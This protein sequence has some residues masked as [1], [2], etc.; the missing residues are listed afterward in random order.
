M[1]QL[2]R[3]ISRYKILH[4]LFWAYAAFSDYHIKSTY[5]KFPEHNFLPEVLTFIGFQILCVY[6]VVAHLLPRLFYR[7][8]IILFFVFMLL[9][10]GV[11]AAIYTVFTWFFV[12]FSS[13]HGS[14]RLGIVHFIVFVF[15]TTTVV[16]V[17]TFIMLIA[18]YFQKERLNKELEKERLEAEL[19]FLKAQMNPHFLFNAINSIYVLMDEDKK[20][21]KDTLMR[22]SSMLR[23]QLYGCAH[24][25]TSIA[26]E[27]EFLNNYIAL[28]KIRNSE[29]LH[30]TFDF[31][32][33]ESQS[34]IA[35]LLL[36]PFVENA[37]KHVSHFVDKPNFVTISA[38]ENEGRFLFTVENSFEKGRVNAEPGGIGLQNV[39]RRLQLLYAD[40][41]HL[42]I[43][44]DEDR[45]AV[46]LNIRIA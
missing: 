45:Y 11:I 13:A 14:G 28:E 37:F 36:I 22:F 5:S 15:D 24:P 12:D 19:D 29:N 26:Q 6:V 8:K 21:S 39:K 3:F 35:P 31:S 23:Y 18:H 42:L 10:I 46:T 2:L 41:H 16:I 1:K 9:T 43:A 44:E 32:C 30:V 34:N 7:Q 17:Y 20:Q 33:P 40:K 27:Y 25:T 38:T 4:I